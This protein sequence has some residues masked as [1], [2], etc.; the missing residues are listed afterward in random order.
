[1]QLLLIQLKQ[2]VFWGVVLQVAA[3][4]LL[5]SGD[6]VVA[7]ALA[8]R[9]LPTRLR[10]WGMTLGTVAAMVLTILF[11][12]VVS[13]LMSLPYLKIIGGLALIYVAW[14][15]EAPQTSREGK[16]VSPNHSIWRAAQLIA[17]TNVVMSFDNVI[18]IAAAA[19]GDL[20]AI[21]VALTISVPMVIGGATVLMAM[22]NRLPVLVWAGAGFLGWIAGEAIATD[23]AVEAAIRN[24]MSA[25]AA[26]EVGVAI[27]LGSAMLVLLARWRRVELAG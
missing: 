16:I 25:E 17:V 9:D 15:L 4:N 3:I 2:P 8:C 12:G 7:I 18:A 14:D 13:V 6:N 1:M 26:Q 19:R 21:A 23:P 22:L 20:S 11:A 24:S 5:L 10:R 27:A